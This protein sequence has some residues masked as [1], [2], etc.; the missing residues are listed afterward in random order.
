MQIPQ[1]PSTLGVRK[2][3]SEKAHNFS[4]AVCGQN[5]SGDEKHPR[6]KKWCG[7]AKVMPAAGNEGET[8]PG[9]GLP[10]LLGYQFPNQPTRPLWNP[11]TASN[12]QGETINIVI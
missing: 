2:T 5:Q 12:A 7:I 9:H 3:S 8:A 4:T 11:G 10:V 1:N 6:A